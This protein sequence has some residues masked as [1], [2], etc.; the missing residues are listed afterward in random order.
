MAESGSAYKAGGIGRLVPQTSNPVLDRRHAWSDHVF[1]LEDGQASAL[2]PV[3][4]FSAKGLFWCVQGEPARE[5]MTLEKV[6]RLHREHQAGDGSNRDIFAAVE[7]IR[8][9]L[10]EFDE[11]TSYYHNT[12]IG[13][14]FDRVQPLASVGTALEVLRRHGIVID[15][16]GPM[17]PR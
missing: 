5:I 7:M 16:S 9:A 12:S 8:R 6:W 4:A 3:T 15:L 1:R 2:R 10:G 13:E 14:R 11:G 17:R